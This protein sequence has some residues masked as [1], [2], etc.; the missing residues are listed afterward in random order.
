MSR[1][2]LADMFLLLEAQRYLEN[3]SNNYIL[4]I[5]QLNITE[6]IY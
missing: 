3:L 5:P 4:P 1:N 2:Q 6:N